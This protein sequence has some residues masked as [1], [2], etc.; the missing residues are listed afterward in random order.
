[1]AT[2]TN[3]STADLADVLFVSMLQESEAPTPTRVRLV[4]EEALRIS[5]GDCAACAA[6]V[7]Q[8]AGDHPDEYARRMHWALTTVETVYGRR[9]S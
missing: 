5:G 4:I 3:S 2:I 8:E 7:A 9:A 1:M 6:C